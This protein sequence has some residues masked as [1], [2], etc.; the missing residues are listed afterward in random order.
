MNSRSGF[1]AVVERGGA[2]PAPL[3][4]RQEA[5]EPKLLAGDTGLGYC[6]KHYGRECT[7]HQ[8]S[9]ARGASTGNTSAAAVAPTPGNLSSGSLATPTPRPRLD[10]GGLD[11][12]GPAGFQHAL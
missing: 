5:A 6:P 8:Y 4:A 10:G 1:E 12:V 11:S 9:S 3:R 2:G 7:A